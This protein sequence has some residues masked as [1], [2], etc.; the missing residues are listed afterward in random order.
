M[1][2][3]K[4]ENGDK[5]SAVHSWS[6]AHSLHPIS[7]L[8]IVFE[9]AESLGC[10]TEDLACQHVSFLLQLGKSEEAKVLIRKLCNGKF[11]HAVHL[12]TLCL[13]MEMRN[14]Q[15]KLPFTSKADLSSIFTV[16]IDV[17]KKVSI[18]EAENLWL[19]VC[20]TFH[21]FILS[22]LCSYAYK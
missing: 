21:C 6:S 12:W 8:Q 9:K 11:S 4:N 13:S 20:R 19:M 16:L 7:H 3:I 2:A 14:I 1:D 10:I 15:N 18:S 22:K 5:M 17:L